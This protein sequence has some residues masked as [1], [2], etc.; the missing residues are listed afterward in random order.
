MTMASSSRLPHGEDTQ[1]DV[2][3]KGFVGSVDLSREETNKTFDINASG[4]VQ[5]LERNFS[6]ISLVGMALSVGNVWPA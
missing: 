3:A 4:H 5:E 6:L 2:V 1:D